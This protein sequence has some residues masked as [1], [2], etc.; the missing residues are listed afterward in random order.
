MVMT[1]GANGTIFSPEKIWRDLR[2]SMDDLADRNR[3][4]W[5][6]SIRKGKILTSW[7]NLDR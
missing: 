1:D 3:V 4:G 7:H 2:K 6:T 5:E